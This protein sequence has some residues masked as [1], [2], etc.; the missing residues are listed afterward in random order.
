M[1][2]LLVTILAYLFLAL[3]SL[4]DRYLLAGPLPDPK[5]YAFYVNILG[6]F[7]ILILPF[8]VKIPSFY[9]ILLSFSVGIIWAIATVLLYRAI[10]QSEA[11][12]IVPAIGGFVP[13]LTL[14]ISKIFFKGA[15]GISF[16][17]IFALAFLILGSVLVT[18][19]REK[20][21][22]KRDLKASFWV[23]LLFSLGFVLM[24]VVYVNQ[25]LLSG[26]ILMKL[27]GGIGALCLLI[28][29]QVR[30]TVFVKKS[31]EKTQ[32]SLPFLLGQVFGG[33]GSA[34][35]NVAIFLVKPNQVPIINA[36]EGIKY[37]FLLGFIFVLAKKY[38]QILKEET[39][40]KAIFQKL[41]A[42]LFIGIG[43]VLLALK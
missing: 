43:L 37:I 10:L 2:W 33:V 14:V 15:P 36:L 38:P 7:A 42:V 40:K 3:T 29:P 22:T 30:S 9:Q 34:L 17:E 1:L 25:S 35:Q 21:I 28:F 41:L 26:F 16:F 11:S 6:I 20:T 4:A 27:G 5:S 18:L 8:G 24:K 39:S 31:I 19:E 12:K 23:A 32:I 13:I